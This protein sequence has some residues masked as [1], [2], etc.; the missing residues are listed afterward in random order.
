MPDQTVQGITR[1]ISIIIKLNK[2]LASQGSD[3]IYIVKIERDEYYIEFADQ[4][5]T[6]GKIHSIDEDLEENIRFWG[7][8]TAESRVHSLS[9]VKLEDNDA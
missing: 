1:M 7:Q 9:K 6:N 5:I 8:A 2:E 4:L 3:D